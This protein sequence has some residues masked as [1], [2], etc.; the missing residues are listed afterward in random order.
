MQGGG[1]PSEFLDDGRESFGADAGLE[2]GDE[3][4]ERVF[5]EPGVEEG[6]DAVGDWDI[7]GRGVHGGGRGGGEGERSAEGKGEGCTF[8][9][10]GTNS[11]QPRNAIVDVV[12]T[13]KSFLRALEAHR[14]H[15]GWPKV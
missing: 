4:A 13:V 2:E 12:L 8:T 10:E 7:E 6:A 3:D 1:F 11:S 5:G 14:V 15:I 9:R